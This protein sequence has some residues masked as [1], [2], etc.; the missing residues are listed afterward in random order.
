MLGRPCAGQAYQSITRTALEAVRA[1]GAPGVGESVA[2]GC[3]SVVLVLL[4]LEDT[5]NRG[6]CECGHRGDGWC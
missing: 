4:R 3:I 1:T 2:R 6:K 5:A